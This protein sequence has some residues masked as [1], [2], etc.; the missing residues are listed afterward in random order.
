MSEIECN[1]LLFF[2]FFMSLVCNLYQY[3]YPIKHVVGKFDNE[4]LTKNT[5]N[6]TDFTNL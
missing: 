5:P 3:F 1:S 4:S 2:A 6:S